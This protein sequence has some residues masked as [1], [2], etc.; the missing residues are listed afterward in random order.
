MKRSVG[1]EVSS[2][3]GDLS[4]L[5][6]L[7]YRPVPQSVGSNFF[8]MQYAY[9]F[10][11][12]QVIRQILVNRNKKLDADEKAALEA[13]DRDRVAEAARLEGISFEQAMERRK[14]YRYLY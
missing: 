8:T 7:V 13:A 11:V 12:F 10:L 4:R 3:F 2:I 14:I 1:A 9:V 6:C 5:A